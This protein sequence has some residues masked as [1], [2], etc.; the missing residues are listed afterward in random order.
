MRFRFIRVLFFIMFLS[1]LIYIPV[2]AQSILSYGAGMTGAISATSPVAIYTFQGEAG[3]SVTVQVIGLTPGLQPAISLNSL[4]GAQL[5]SSNSDTTNLASASARLNVTLAESGIHTIIVAS[6][7]GSPGDF[8]IR[9]DGIASSAQGEVNED[10]ASGTVTP[11][12]SVLVYTVPGNADLPLLATV[13]TD[14]DGAVFSV[15]VTSPDGLQI[16][17]LSGSSQQ[18]AITTLPVSTGEYTLQITVNT[19]VDATINVNVA[20]IGEAID[21]DEDNGEIVEATPTPLPD[22]GQATATYTPTVAPDN[23]VQATATF[24]PS[25]TPTAAPN[26]NAQATATTTASYTPTTAPNNNVQPTATFTPSYTPTNQPTATFTPSYTPTTPPAQV[27]P[28]DARFNNPLNI[29]LDSTASVLDFVSYPD[30][31]TEDRVRFSVT[32]MNNNSS[33]SG[34]RARLVI[35]VTCF[36]ENTDEVQFFTG[37]QTYSCGQTIVDREVTA[38]SDTGS[39]VITAVGGSGTYVQW[40]LTGTATRVN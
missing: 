19:P 26:N 27:A 22:D 20:P 3:D 24:T 35:S 28:D 14:G 39:V 16:G 33:L 23:N 32:G 11:G 15:S 34:G 31:D 10:G 17:L 13:T 25:Y 8:A 36:G 2:Q 37:G 40:V 9:L 4:T 21:D 12:V 5:G 18:N 38:D 1:L 29:P 6:L 7:N 30:G